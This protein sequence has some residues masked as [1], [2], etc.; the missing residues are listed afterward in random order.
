MPKWNTLVSACEEVT[1]ETAQEAIDILA[2][3]LSAAGFE[4]YT[5]HART[6]DAFLSENSEE[7]EEDS[8]DIS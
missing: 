6:P 3:R 7:E 4:P 5:D 1:A 2:M 8:E